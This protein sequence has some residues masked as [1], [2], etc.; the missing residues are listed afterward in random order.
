MTAR[1][2]PKIEIERLPDGFG[3]YHWK[4]TAPG[5]STYHERIDEVEIVVSVLLRN[6]GGV[7]VK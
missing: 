3:R 7:G 4:I 1:Y 5:H 6:M 2:G